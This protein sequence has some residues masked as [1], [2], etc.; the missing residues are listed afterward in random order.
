MAKSDPAFL[1]QLHEEALKKQESFFANISTRLGRA[2][3]LQSAPA[4]PMKGLPLLGGYQ[5]SA[6]GAYSALHVELAKA[7]GHTYRL[8]GMTEAQA[9][10]TDFISKTQAKNL[11]I[12]DQPELE[13]LRASLSADTETN[14]TV[15]NAQGATAE[16]KDEL[17]AKAAGADIGI[18]AVEHVVAYTAR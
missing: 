14:I 9:F 15:W 3:P 18:V 8:S 5:P 2:K 17:V 11:I 7:G 1:Q 6:G 13:M 4:H 10:I 12:Q 16:A